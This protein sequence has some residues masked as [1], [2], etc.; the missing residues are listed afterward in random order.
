[1]PFLNAA[2]AAVNPERWMRNAA[3]IAENVAHTGP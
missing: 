2:P 3:C 1:M